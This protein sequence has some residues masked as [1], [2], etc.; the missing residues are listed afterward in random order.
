MW[1]RNAE[2]LVRSMTG[3]LPPSATEAPTAYGS[4]VPRWP[5]FWFQ[6]TSCGLACE[7]VHRK[8]TVAPP[9]RTM[10]PSSGKALVASTTKRAGWIGVL[11]VGTARSVGVNDGRAV[12]SRH[13]LT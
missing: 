7:Y 2:S 9:S 11:P 10:M 4:P 3:R 1:N 12:L 13:T 6:M 5:K 8:I